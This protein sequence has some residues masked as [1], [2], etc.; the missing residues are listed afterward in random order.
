MKSTRWLRSPDA[1]AETVS[2][3]AVL[4]RLSTGDYFEIPT[5]GAAVWA[6]LEQPATVTDLRRRLTE[7]FDVDPDRAE[8]D[9]SRF[10]LEL[11]SAGLVDRVGE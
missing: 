9:I 3:G 10:L 1:L 8:Q 6:G 2:D 5:T 7:T 4:L 11:E